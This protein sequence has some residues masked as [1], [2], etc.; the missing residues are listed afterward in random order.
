MARAN[1]PCCIPVLL[2]WDCLLEIVVLFTDLWWNANN[3]LQKKIQ[4]V[5]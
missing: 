5:S 3:R 1:I 2:D 4:K